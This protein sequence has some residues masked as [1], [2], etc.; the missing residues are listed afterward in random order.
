M[1]I[2]YQFTWSPIFG[3]LYTPVAIPVKK[4]KK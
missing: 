1:P 4:R 2:K 3:L